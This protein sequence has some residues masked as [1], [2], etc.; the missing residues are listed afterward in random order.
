M[1]TP[2]AMT[3]YG[4]A[5]SNRV[6]G[7]PAGRVTSDQRKM[8][9]VDRERRRWRIAHCA[10]LNTPYLR[11]GT[12]LQSREARRPTDRN[13]LM[14]YS[15]LQIQRGCHVINVRGRGAAQCLTGNSCG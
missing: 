10:L 5:N 12:R 1:S 4:G 2:L 14:L 9:V 6:Q 8:R 11:C 15:I 3:D 7:A 13:G